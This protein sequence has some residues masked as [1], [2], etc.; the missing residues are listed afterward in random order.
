MVTPDD[1]GDMIKQGLN[2]FNNKPSSL[3]QLASHVNNEL[4]DWISLWNSKQ[5]NIITCD[6]F[7][8]CDFVKK[9]VEL[10]KI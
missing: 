3:V 1:N 7:D 8:Q 10:N 2:P 9:V 6:S 4:I 5:I